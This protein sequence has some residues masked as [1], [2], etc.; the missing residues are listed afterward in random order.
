MGR[1][2]EGKAEKQFKN[3]GKQIDSLIKDLKQYKE[4][5]K[6]EYSDQIDELKRNRD[7]LEDEFNDFRKSDR[8]DVVEEKLEKAADEI[9]D[10]FKGLFNKKKSEGESREN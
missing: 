5:V 6:V 3:F 10:A 2:P 8:W 4:K 9:R 1:K 7:T